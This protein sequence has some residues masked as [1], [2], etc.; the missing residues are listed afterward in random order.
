[1]CAQGSG[2][3]RRD[4]LTVPRDDAALPERPWSAAFQHAEPYLPPDRPGS[5]P[6][7]ARCPQ[8]ML[9]MLRPARPAQAQR[10]GNPPCGPSEPIIRQQADEPMPQA[11]Q[12][13]RV[14]A[15]WPRPRWPGPP[16][17]QSPGVGGQPGR[18]ARTLVIQLPAA[19]CPGPARRTTLGGTEHHRRADPLVARPDGSA[20]I[21]SWGSARR[22]MG[23]QGCPTSMPAS[24]S[25]SASGP[26]RSA[27]ATS[28]SPWCTPRRMVSS[29][30]PPS[31]GRPGSPWPRCTRATRRDAAH[32][33]HALLALGDLPHPYARASDPP[34]AC[35]A[36]R[37]LGPRARGAGR[38]EPRLGRGHAFADAGEGHGT[39]HRT[40]RPAYPL[41]PPL[42]AVPNGHG[43]MA[44]PSMDAWSGRT[45][46]PDAE[47]RHGPPPS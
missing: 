31:T 26:A 13:Q 25:A 15:C 4:A 20:D 23:S 6:G 42:P 29:S 19:L 46:E 41:G 45:D 24:P 16:S 36:A 34:A 38:D 5:A 12:G 28:T 11:A 1:M 7:S 27:S 21:P 14:P 44:L 9:L 33:L 10:G 3:K 22:P 35:P 17:G 32:F 37:K 30:L 18:R 43:S 39:L 47:G 2:S 40:T 8:G